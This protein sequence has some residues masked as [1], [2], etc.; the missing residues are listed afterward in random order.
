DYL[1]VVAVSVKKKIA[2]SLFEHRPGVWVGLVEKQA[3]LGGNHIWC[4]HAGDVHASALSYVSKL[5]T[6]SWPRYE[7][8]FP[9]LIR[10]LEQPYA[11]VRSERLNEVVQ[12]A[13]FERPGAR[14][15]LE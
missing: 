13:F 11:A 15:F 4:F 6:V 8:R 2:L 12:S 14:L 7:V 3:T 5:V 1:S 10:T 9:E